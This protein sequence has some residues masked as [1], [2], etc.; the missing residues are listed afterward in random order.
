MS[1]FK[2]AVEFMTDE[3]ENQAK[4]LE[5]S[6]LN[7][8]EDKPKDKEVDEKKKA[9]KCKKCGATHW[10]FQKCGAKKKGKDD[11]K[12]EKPKKKSKKDMEE[13]RAAWKKRL[14]ERRRRIKEEAMDSEDDYVE[15]TDEKKECDE[16][17]LPCGCMG[18]CTCE[19]KKECDESKVNEEADSKEKQRNEKLLKGEIVY[20]EFVKGCLGGLA[21]VSIVEGALVLKNDHG[22]EV[23]FDLPKE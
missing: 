7:E 20:E 4:L 2:D 17:K 13:R 10:P 1:D 12:E 14:A 16:E 9:P 22:K 15:P 3:I 23:K 6:K 8:S 5:D 19:E 21:E 18:K 11:K